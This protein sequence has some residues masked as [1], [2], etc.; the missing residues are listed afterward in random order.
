MGLH[1]ASREKIEQGRGQEWRWSE[2]SGSGSIG[3]GVRFCTPVAVSCI[4]IRKPTFVAIDYHH[5]G[6]QLGAS[7]YLAG[8]ILFNWSLYAHKGLIAR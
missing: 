6:R 3:K 8:L 1:K 5:C 2:G 4:R 7:D